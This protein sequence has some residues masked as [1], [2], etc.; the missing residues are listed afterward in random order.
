MTVTGIFWLHF[1]TEERRMVHHLPVGCGQTLNLTSAFFFSL[2]EKKEKK[3]KFG[4]I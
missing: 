3:V 2:S 1:S 4:M